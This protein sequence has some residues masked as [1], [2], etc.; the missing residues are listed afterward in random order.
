MP[1]ALCISA[2]ETPMPESRPRSRIV[3]VYQDPPA[4]SPPAA[5]PLLW[6]APFWHLCT[7]AAVAWLIV[8]TRGP[9]PSGCLSRPPVIRLRQQWPQTASREQKL[10]LC[11]SGARV[12][13][14]P[15]LTPIEQLPNHYGAGIP[16]STRMSRESY[17]ADVFL[18]SGGSGANCFLLNS[19]RGSSGS[20]SSFSACAI[21]SRRSPA[22]LFSRIRQRSERAGSILERPSGPFLVRAP[23]CPAFELQSAVIIPAL[24][25]LAQVFR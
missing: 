9:A 4:P 5:R 20:R 24:T 1:E 12:L 19:R 22:A 16:F 18:H 8:Y 6:A 3:G 17:T 23:S 25:F 10:W 14:P 21:T 11:L 13:R 7:R 15:C 2:A